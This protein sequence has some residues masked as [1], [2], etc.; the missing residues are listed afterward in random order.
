MSIAEEDMPFI[1][2]TFTLR[3][4]RVQ[5][6]PLW[7]AWWSLVESSGVLVGQGSFGRLLDDLLEEVVVGRAGLGAILYQMLEE[8]GFR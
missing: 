6:V 7:L 5:S 8:G 3:F 1:C 2:P 4:F